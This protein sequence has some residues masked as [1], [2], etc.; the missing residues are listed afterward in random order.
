MTNKNDNISGFKKTT[1]TKR[2]HS[3]THNALCAQIHDQNIMK[4]TIWMK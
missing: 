4:H 2:T 1:K 3:F